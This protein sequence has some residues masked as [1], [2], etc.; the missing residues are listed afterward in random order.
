MGIFSEVA[1]WVEN[2]PAYEFWVCAV[3]L[4]IICGVSFFRTFSLVHRKRIIEDTP[5]T[6]IRS[7]SQGYVELVGHGHLI[8]GQPITSPFSGNTCLWYEYQVEKQT[9]TSINYFR[10][11]VWR[12]V[13]R[14]A[15][16]SLFLL[17]D[18]TGQCIID[19]E[20]ASVTVK[21]G[22]VWYGNS[23]MPSS[24][25][26]VA[27]KIS[28]LNKFVFPG[29]FGSNFNNQY[30]YTERLLYPGDRLYAIGLYETIGGADAEFD[31]NADVCD[32]LREWKED[33]E[34]LKKRFDT[35]KDGKLSMQE[36]QKVREAAY[37]DVT[38]THGARKKMAPINLMS[39]TNDSRQSFILSSIE[40]NTLTRKLHLHSMLWFALFWIGGIAAFYLISLRL[41]S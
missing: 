4:V 31:V 24:R 34:T 15:S 23:D 30:R 8:E 6:N 10:G 14:E 38:K 16:D 18:E 12:T 5:T 2:A 35:N 32:L 7:A 29:G 36:W 41:A 11:Y 28:D 40:Q 22:Y 21:D 3:L 33:T 19:P 13:R 39:K 27:R 9:T 37:Q 25:S 17:K 26:P 1:Q 20:G